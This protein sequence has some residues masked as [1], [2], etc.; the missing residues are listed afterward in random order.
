MLADS[1]IDKTV[2]NRWYQRF[3]ER[4]KLDTATQRPLEISREKWCTSANLKKHYDVLEAAL[5]QARVAVSNPRHDPADPYSPSIILTRPER[6]FSFDE[7]RLT[8]DCTD[9]NKSKGNR[10]VT[11]GLDDRGDTLSSKGGGDG[12][13]VGGSFADGHGQ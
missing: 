6:L 12:T 7:T 3:L 13:G 1:G 10:I 2:T 11:S 9:S 5:L 4:H 8:M